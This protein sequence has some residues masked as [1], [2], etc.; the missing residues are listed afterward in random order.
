MFTQTTTQTATQTTTQ[1]QPATPKTAFDFNATF[2]AES[3]TSAGPALHVRHL[4]A[5]AQPT[6]PTYTELPED[7]RRIEIDRALPRELRECARGM[8]WGL[9]M[10]TFAPEPTLDVTLTHEEKLNWM[11]NEYHFSVHA[12]PKTRPPRETSE[13]AQASGPIRAIGDVLSRH[14]RYVEILSFHQTEIF[15]Q[16]LTMVKVGHSERHLLTH[17]AIGFGATPAESAAAAMSAGA[18]RIHGNM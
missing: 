11:L 15:G 13:T 2:N 5:P 9:F 17:W 10:A 8:D 7:L 4:P 6:A 3:E 12:M 14:G 18:Q 16:S 1:A